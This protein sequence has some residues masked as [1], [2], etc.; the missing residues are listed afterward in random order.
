MPSVTW[1]P[2]DGR[3][4]AY[5]NECR[6]EREKKG[7]VTSSTYLGSTPERAAEKLRRLVQ[8]EGEYS[9]LVD[10]LYRKRPAGKPP[11]SEEE[12]AALSL[13]RLA[14]R[15]ESP[16]VQEAVKAAL[17]VLQGESY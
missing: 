8:D 10:D 9:R 11:G 3:Y 14:R 12:K 7:P 4:Y 15:Y 17:A 2:I 13:R 6:Y 16:R 5:L 1:K